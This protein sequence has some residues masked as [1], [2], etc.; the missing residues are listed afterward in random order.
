MRPTTLPWTFFHTKFFPLLVSTQERIGPT[1]NHCFMTGKQALLM[2]I[3]AQSYAAKVLPAVLC[4]CWAFQTLFKGKQRVHVLVV[5]PSWLKEHVS[6]WPA[7]LLREQAISLTWL[8]FQ[9]VGMLPFSYTSQCAESQILHVLRA[10]VGRFFKKFSCR[11]HVVVQVDLHHHK[12]EYP[13]SL[14]F[15]FKMPA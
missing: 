2:S 9:H 3:T 14:C 6:P 15:L 13:S 1:S 11:T 4:T 5:H 7:F 12:P 8:G 10:T